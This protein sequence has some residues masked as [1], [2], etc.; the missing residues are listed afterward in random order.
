MK[1]L[2]VTLLMLAFFVMP[3]FAADIRV[4]EIDVQEMLI[5]RLDQEKTRYTNSWSD[6]IITLRMRLSWHSVPIR[7]ANN[8]NL[9]IQLI[10][11]KSAFIL[12]NGQSHRI[13]PGNT[14]KI[15]SELSV[16]PAMIPPHTSYET[17]AFVLGL[18]GPRG[19][20]QDMLLD[21][22]ITT[23]WS[24]P[25]GIAKRD[26]KEYARFAEKYE[27]KRL[28]MLLCF[29]IGGQ[30]Q[31]YQFN[32]NLDFAEGIKN[33]P[34]IGDDGKEVERLSIG[35]TLAENKIVEVEK[36][37]LAE[38]AGLLENDI[39]TE[40]NLSPADTVKNIDSY[41]MEKLRAGSSV[42]L[43]CDRDGEP[44]LITLKK[45]PK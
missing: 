33:L 29:D 28:T 40:I 6:D 34:Q 12:T 1:K 21:Y 25:T 7:L 26:S 4:A 39:I 27:G 22:P 11:D 16:P 14:R 24:T 13:V 3:A 2:L 45:T 8:S 44:V 38:K 18:E 9:I 32:I 19:N 36:N 5:Q 37:G 20:R 31:F 17:M 23:S 43:L 15:H 35:W 42:M 30:E 41:C 10:W